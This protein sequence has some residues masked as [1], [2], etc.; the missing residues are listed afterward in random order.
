MVEISIA[1]YLIPQA[2]VDRLAIA[3]WAKAWAVVL[4]KQIVDDMIARGE[5][6]RLKIVKRLKA[7]R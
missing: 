5:T 3:E 6:S 4:D 2:G 7:K 1:P